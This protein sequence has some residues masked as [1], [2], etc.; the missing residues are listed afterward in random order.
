MTWRLKELLR[1]RRRPRPAESRPSRPDRNPPVTVITLDPALFTGATDLALRGWARQTGS[2]R[3]LMYGPIPHP[4]FAEGRVEMLDQA[5]HGTAGM[6]YVVGWS[7]GARI[8][9]KWL[10]DKGPTSP[11]D[12]S[13]IV[14]I[15]L[16]N[17]ERKH[18]GVCV[19]PSPPRKLFGL[20]NPEADYGGCGVPE[21]TRYR[22]FDLA[23]Q[24]GGWE[25]APNVVAPSATALGA[26]SDAYHMDYF[27]VSLDDDMLIHTENNV[28][29]GLW[30]TGVPNREIVEAS[31]RRPPYRV[32]RLQVAA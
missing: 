32:G 28:T 5:I 4:A 8:A 15:L 3:R 2:V 22:V 10:R 27:S 11:V 20:I 29:H 26:L 12:P 19:V 31:Y 30:V 25:D 23:R 16:G 14:F 1:R 21:D 9:A 13:R 6:V 7:E 24:Y 17:P 18:G